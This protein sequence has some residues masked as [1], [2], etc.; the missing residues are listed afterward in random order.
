MFYRLFP[1][2][3]CLMNNVRDPSERNVELAVLDRQVL[4]ISVAIGRFTGK[5]CALGMRAF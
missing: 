4:E 5:Q 2:A 3:F 1:N